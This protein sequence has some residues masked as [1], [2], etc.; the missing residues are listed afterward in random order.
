L[1]LLTIEAAYVV[2]FP[3]EHYP[4]FRFD[5]PEQLFAGTQVPVIETC[6]ICP[7]P[8]RSPY[9]PVPQNNVTFIMADKSACLRFWFAY[10]PV[11][12]TL[13]SG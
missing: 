2:T 5:S 12:F 6:Q 1:L 7:H 10:K 3:V 11:G 13:S 4:G 9:K 8:E